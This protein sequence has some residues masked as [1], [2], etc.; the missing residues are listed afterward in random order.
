[1][2]LIL[3]VGCTVIVAVLGNPLQLFDIGVTVMVATTSKFDV[4][5]AVK[6]LMVPEPDAANPM[7]VVLFAQL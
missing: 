7:E 4:L 6:E 2:V 5:T 3:G 1:M